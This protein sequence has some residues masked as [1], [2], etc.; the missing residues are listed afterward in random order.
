MNRR[1]AGHERSLLVDHP[2]VTQRRRTTSTSKLA[3]IFG[4]ETEPEKINTLLSG[5]EDLAIAGKYAAKTAESQRRGAEKLARWA[6]SS[7][8]T[9]ID[10]AMKHS[11]EL[12][13][14]FADKQTQFARDYDHFLQQFKKI[15]ETEKLVKERE[16]EVKILVEKERKLQKEIYKGNGI[17]GGRRKSAEILQLREQ[18]E[19]III[20]RELSERRLTE[21]RAEAEIIIDRELSERRLTETRAEA[22]VIKMFRVRHGMM[23]IADAY[24]NLA[25]H[26]QAI[27]DCHREILEMVPAVSTQDVYQM[28]YDGIPYTRERVDALRRSL[29]NEIPIEYNPPSARRRSEPIRQHRSMGALRNHQ[30]Q[31][32]MHS[33]PPPYTPTAPPCNYQS[34]REESVLITPLQPRSTN[35][36]SETP[37]MRPHMNFRSRSG[38]LRRSEVITVTT[39][40]PRESSPSS[41]SE[42]PRMRPHMNFRSRSG[43]LRRSEVTTVTTTTPPRESSP[44]SSASSSDDSPSDP[45]PP[46]PQNRLYP[47]LSFSSTDSPNIPI[48]P[49]KKFG[50]PTNRTT[51]YA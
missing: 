36:N 23:G 5:L 46:Q 18:L 7:R 51:A 20:D 39:T 43:Q 2:N 45:P 37:R 14:F 32:L 41:S 28:E 50:I 1:S 27:F 34:D 33:P 13:S 47:S 31:P 11:N 3:S 17:F 21:T 40:P 15:I 6:H 49:L 38:Q 44:Y 12:F 29:D 16:T 10:D 22:E 24:R 48:C 25:T 35:N 9:A 8:N 26:C 19:R 4:K 42:T 30:Q